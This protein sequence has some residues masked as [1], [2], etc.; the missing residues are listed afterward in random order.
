MAGEDRRFFEV[1]PTLKLP[2]NVR[3]LFEQVQVVRVIRSEKKNA[4]RIHVKCADW[5][6]KETI[7]EAEE[8]IAAQVF[9]RSHAKVN[10]VERFALSSQYNP[11]NFYKAYRSSMVKE[12]ETV[13]PLLA[14]LFKRSELVFTAQ[15]EIEARIPVNPILTERTGELLDYIEKVFAERAGFSR[16][17]IRPVYVDPDRAALFAE[18]AAKIESHVAAIVKRSKK[19][20]EAPKEE[21][22]LPA[23][24]KRTRQA[25]AF[26]SKDPNVILG[27][28]FDEPPIPMDTLGEEPREVVVRGEVFQVGERELKTGKTILTVALTDYTDSIRMK[29]WANPEELP[30]YKDTFKKG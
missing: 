30:I 28:G 21:E 22:K 25:K 24:E 1:F 23:Q 11:Q 8:A 27:R 5:I 2:E 19:R 10:L 14:L 15:E 13:S 29:L 7:Y 6:K 4:Y 20:E 9:P 12:L 16:C 26:V 3:E 17:E 18:D